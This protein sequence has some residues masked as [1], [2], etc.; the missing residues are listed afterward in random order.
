MAS[1][2]RLPTSNAFSTVI[3]W[4]LAFILPGTTL[5]YII[6][7]LALALLVASFANS[8]RPSYKLGCIE[9][10]LKGA[11]EILE[12]AKANCARNQVE[13]MDLTS[14]LHDSA[15]IFR[16]KLSASK[17]QTRLLNTSNAID[18]M[19]YLQ[20]VRIIMQ[21]IEEAAKKV[22]KI[23]TST[24]LT[25]EAERQHEFSEDFRESRSSTRLFPRRRVRH[26]R[27][28]TRRFESASTANASNASYM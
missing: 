4:V 17:I 10:A 20:S 11:E 18:W 28:A 9:D 21:S 24:L 25:I 27:A 6:M 3:F 19:E 14:R 22:K 15:N 8:Q 7:G 12:G 26:V 2:S 16:A 1:T 23:Q 13:W 5:R